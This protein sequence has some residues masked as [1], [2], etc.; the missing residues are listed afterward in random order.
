MNQSRRAQDSSILRPA[1]LHVSPLLSDGLLFVFRLVQADFKYTPADHISVRF[2]YRATSMLAAADRLVNPFGWRFSCRTDWSPSTQAIRPH[3][4]RRRGRS[5]SS[6][7][8]SPP[9]AGSGS[10]FTGAS[11]SSGVTSTEKRVVPHP[12]QR[13][14]SLPRWC[15]H[16]V[17]VP[18]QIRASFESGSSFSAIT[19]PAL[20]VPSIR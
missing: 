17:Q 8:Q 20:P 16:P 3:G 15:N 7:P 2:S 12:F 5:R 19:L 13:N 14:T 6:L 1:S 11:V 18:S 4:A 10:G 9:S